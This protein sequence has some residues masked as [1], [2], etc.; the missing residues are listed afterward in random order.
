MLTW[1][2]AGTDTKG[3]G[4]YAT[5]KPWNVDPQAFKLVTPWGKNGE[6]LWLRVFVLETSDKLHMTRDMLQVTF[7]R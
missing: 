1:L 2:K 7:D 4:T 6:G 5:D 3:K